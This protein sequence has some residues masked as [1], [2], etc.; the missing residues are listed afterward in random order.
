M[1]N[2]EVA[3]LGYYNQSRLHR[4]ENGDYTLFEFG[5]KA[6]V[7]IINHLLRE[8]GF[9]AVSIADAV[10]VAGKRTGH[11]VTN[12]PWAKSLELQSAWHSEIIPVVSGERQKQL[13]AEEAKRRRIEKANADLVERN[14]PIIKQV[15]GEEFRSR[16]TSYPR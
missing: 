12:M 16:L 11:M 5:S 15:T 13:D 3:N 6:D 14:K 10:I 7:I 2:L 1:K 8:L 9:D 4:G